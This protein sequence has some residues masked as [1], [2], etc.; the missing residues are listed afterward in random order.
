MWAHGD[1]ANK[2]EVTA[3]TPAGVSTLVRLTTGTPHGIT[4]TNLVSVEGVTGTIEKGTFP[5]RQT[6]EI[7]GVAGTNCT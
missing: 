2:V 6:K 5:G 4:D 7:C 3:I 1:Y